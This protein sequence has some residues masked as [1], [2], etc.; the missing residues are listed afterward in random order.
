VPLIV[1]GPYDYGDPNARP[2]ADLGGLVG[3]TGGG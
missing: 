2:V 1:A 3:A